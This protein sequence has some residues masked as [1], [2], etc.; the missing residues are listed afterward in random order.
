ME[1]AISAKKTSRFVKFR[2]D[3]RQRWDLNHSIHYIRAIR[4]NRNSMPR[5]ADLHHPLLWTNIRRHT[6]KLFVI[7][8]QQLD[9]HQS[10]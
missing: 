5:V 4:T 3:A 10:L 8:A 2:F 6:R 1:D 9:R 7:T